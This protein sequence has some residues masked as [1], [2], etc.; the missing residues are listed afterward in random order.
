MKYLSNRQSARVQ[1]KRKLFLGAFIMA[2]I[3]V[4]IFVRFNIFSPLSSFFHRI[5]V[6]IWKIENT[7]KNKISSTQLLT[8]SK[9]SLLE[10]NELLKKL[11][12]KKER[13]KSELSKERPLRE[14]LQRRER[15]KK[16]LPEGNPQ[17]VLRG[18]VGS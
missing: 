1:K 18:G 5:A 7:F 3:I 14:G 4:F 6:P 16:P 11:L 8:Q 17:N 13:P 9:K 2:V 10:E 15:L 12:S